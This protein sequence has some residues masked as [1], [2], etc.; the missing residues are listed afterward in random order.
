MSAPQTQVQNARAL[1][2]RGALADAERA[3]QSVL[4][5]DPHNAAALHGL[6]VLALQR[7]EPE[8]AES[9]LARAV[10][11]DPANAAAWHDRALAL[12]GLERPKRSLECLDRAIALDATFAP[13]HFTRGTVLLRT[14]RNEAAVE[15]FT[16][17]IDRDPK[18]FAAY[19][20]RA[21]ALRALNRLEE[22]VSDYTEAAALQ[23]NHPAILCNLGFALQDVGRFDE[24]AAAYNRAVIAH[25][26]YHLAYQIRGTLALLQGRWREGFADFESRLKSSPLPDPGLAKIPYW[27]GENLAGKSIAIYSDGAF[28]DL[29]QFCRYLPML[30]ERGA[31]TTLLAPKRFHR[32]MGSDAIG[33][34]S[35]SSFAE[36]GAVD[37]RCEL[38][39]LPFL[40]RTDLSSIPP[41]ADHIHR[42]AKKCANWQARLPAGTFNIGIC[43]QGNPARHI[44]RGR[45]IPLCEFAPIARVSGVRLVSLQKHHGLDQLH[46]LPPEMQVEDLGPEFDEGPDAF[47]DTAVVM[48]SLDL[49]VTADTAIAHLAATLGRP[50]W[51]ALRSVPEWRWLLHR[52]DSPWYPSVRLFRQARPN[53]WAPV[54]QD[55]AS[56]V[57]EIAADA[58]PSRFR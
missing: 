56:A 25:P 58:T 51:V 32:I 44:D 20:E 49:V 7:G 38:M 9:L 2:R 52:T 48:R 21:N 4:L 3:Y 27:R 5:S 26:N 42:D 8:K 18:L 46:S 33:V 15:S 55:I 57:R 14:G 13:A 29:V 40:F 50:T 47:M 11:F 35:M 10:A 28:G 39:S 12:R 17:A 45:S 23:P 1:H 16:C 30:V 24:A 36:A 34:R 54:F 6:G 43:W 31:R 41:P 53:D 37:F 22:A 19:N